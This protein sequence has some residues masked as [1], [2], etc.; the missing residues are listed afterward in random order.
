M[1]FVIA[2]GLMAV[3]AVVLLITYTVHA[4]YLP[5]DVVLFSAII[6]AGVAAVIC[7]SV[8]LLVTRIRQLFSSLEIVLI[9]FVWLLGGYSFAIS[10]PTVL[11]RSLSFY[12]LEK[13]DQRGGGIELARISDVF[14]QEYLREFRL[15]EVRLTEQLE[16]GTV[17]IEDGC[18]RLTPW[19]E[20]L[21]TISSYL[22]SAW[23]PRHRLLGD[24][25]S[26]DLTTPLDQ[27]N[28]KVLDYEC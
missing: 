18:V 12:I 4:W 17:V 1:K 19:G 13:L 3:Y 14:T 23:L 21:A 22:R 6:D 11:D 16:S 20:N 28:V 2:F 10:V 8:L 15:V 9:V 24:G 26:S 5:V 7:L 27:K 25:Y